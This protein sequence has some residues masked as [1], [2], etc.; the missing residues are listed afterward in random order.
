M[1]ERTSTAINVTNVVE[2]SLTGIEDV[3]RS[4]RQLARSTSDLGGAAADVLERELA[5][6]IKISQQVRDRSISPEMLKRVRSEGLPARLRKDAHDVVDLVADLT[7]VV[8]VSAFDLLND[9]VDERRPALPNRPTK[10]S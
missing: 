5:M 1:S 8:A 10:S 3:A 6:A 7:S 9:F 4:L 2:E